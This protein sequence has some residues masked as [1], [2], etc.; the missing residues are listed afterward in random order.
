[1]VPLRSVGCAWSGPNNKLDEHMRKCV[2]ELLKDYIAQTND[3]LMSL[4]KQVRVQRDEI[5]ALKKYIATSIAVPSYVPSRPF[6][7]ERDDLADDD[8]A[9]ATT[10]DSFSPFTSGQLPPLSPLAELGASATAASASTAASSGAVSAATAAAAASSKASAA[11]SAAAAAAVASAAAHRVPPDP[12][13]QSSSTT[14]GA[15]VA[16]AAATTMLPGGSTAQ[17]SPRGP[18]KS[19]WAAGLLELQQVFV[20]LFVFVG[21]D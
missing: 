2:F 16:T 12:I 19:R 10:D 4:D 5:R 6:A 1:M 8:G 18:V 13:K 14:A 9:G 7:A 3:R 15:S 11:A 21:V 17:L 20:L